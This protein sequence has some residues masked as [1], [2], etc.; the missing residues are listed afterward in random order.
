MEKRIDGTTFKVE[1]LLATEAIKLQ[2]RL[3]K[4]IGPAMDRLPEILVNRRKGEEDKSNAA[5]ISAFADIFNRADPD[6]MTALVKDVVEIAMIQ[7]PSKSYDPV[8]IDGDFTGKLDLLMKVAV[9]VLQEQFAAFF[10]ASL[11]NG[12]LNRMVKSSATEN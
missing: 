7:R 2:I 1:P 11:A 6:E 10:T 12:A 5:A 8:D 9:F 4:A 3:L